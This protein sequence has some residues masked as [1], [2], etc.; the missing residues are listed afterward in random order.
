M[1]IGSMMI[2]HSAGKDN[3]LRYFI[4][5]GIDGEFATGIYL[6]S[7]MKLGKVNYMKKDIKDPSKFE[8]VGYSKAFDVMKV[9]LVKIFN[10]GD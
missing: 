3:P 4:Y 2:N 10:K 5:T 6:T 8:V 7:K 9:D 1:E